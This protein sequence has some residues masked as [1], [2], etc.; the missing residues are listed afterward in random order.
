MDLGHNSFAMK[1]NQYAGS[2]QI[3][4]AR[5]EAQDSERHVSPMRTGITPFR[6]RPLQVSVLERHEQ[7]TATPLNR[8]RESGLNDTRTNFIMPNYNIMQL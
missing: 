5:T 6:Q 2:F 1:Y 3:F 8:N 7:D 4:S